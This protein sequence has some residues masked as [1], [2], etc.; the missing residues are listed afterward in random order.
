[1]FLEK[2][3][4]DFFYYELKKI[5]PKK[6]SVIDLGCGSNSI[7]RKFKKNITKSYGIEIH[8]ESIK[9]SKKN[10]IHTE[11]ICD[12]AIN[13]KKYFKNKSVDVVFSID[14][15]EHLKKKQAI[16]LI[17]K[18]E[19]IAKKMVIIRTTNGY[20]HQNTYDNNYYQKHLSGFHPVFFKKR[21]YIVLGIDGPYFLRFNHKKE[22]RPKN[23]FVSILANI[24]SPF[25][26][27]L[28]QYSFNF[29]AYKKV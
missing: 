1:M 22:I 23:I 5:F 6:F 28:P 21:N 20:I 2:I 11:Y 13:I 25:F 8:Q 16:L 19:K 3:K 7:L 10:K 26:R 12:N 14:M 4:P 27:Y 24:L 29:L 9:K 18:I 15:I 17:E